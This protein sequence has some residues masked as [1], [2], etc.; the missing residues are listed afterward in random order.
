LKNIIGFIRQNFTFFSFLILQ[1]VSLVMLSSY[2][3]S[4]QTFFG[5]IA[6]QFIGDINT[7]YNNASYFFSLKTTNA[8]LS[9]ENAMLRNQL[10]QN[11]IPF[12]TSKKLGTLVLRKDS[13]EKIRKFY[14]YPAKVV[15][16]TFTLQKNYITIERGALQGVKKDMAAISPDG[17]IVGIVIEV[18]DRYSKIMSLL[19]RNSKV[20]AMLKRDKVAGTVEWDGSDP[21]ILTLKNISKSAAPKIGDSVLTSPYSASFP[22]QL[23]IGRVSKVIVD[24]SSNFLTLE[25][26]SATNFYNLE[27]I[28]LVENRRMNEQFNLEKNKTPNE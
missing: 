20:S 26:K 6:N 4:H 11:F 16:N 7:R 17:S 22:A 9:A 15:G 25:L 8:K 12:D 3:K 18:G 1:I 24:P 5:G 19:H 2:S 14:Y 10:A 21:E 23:M 13:L 28:Y 27:F